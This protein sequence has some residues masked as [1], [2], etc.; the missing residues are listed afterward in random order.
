[1]QFTLSQPYK[2]SGLF[3]LVILRMKS[4][5][6]AGNLLHLHSIGSEII[7]IFL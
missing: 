5:Q 7:P 1:M 3:G 4:S 2:W 6:Y